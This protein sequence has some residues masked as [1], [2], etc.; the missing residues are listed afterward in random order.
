M[1]CYMQHMHW[2]FEALDLPYDK[3]QRIRVDRALRQVI[4]TPEGA[5]CPEV[6]AA[7]K[8]LPAEDRSALPAQIGPLLS[9]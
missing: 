6:W 3:P 5:K 7:V 9:D 2:L 4:G 1:T 8:A